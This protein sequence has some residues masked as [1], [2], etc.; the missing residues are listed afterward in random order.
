MKHL[1]DIQYINDTNIINYNTLLFVSYVANL[2]SK[3]NETLSEKDS[4][5]QEILAKKFAAEQNERQSR[6]E[7]SRLQIEINSYKQRLER[8]EID[9]IHLRRENLRL[10]DQ[11]TFLEKEVRY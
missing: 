9:L 5:E 3:L 8:A 10:T 7:Q 4:I 2:Q 1:F 11:I 6:Q